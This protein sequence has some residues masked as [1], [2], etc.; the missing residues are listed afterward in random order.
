MNMKGAEKF[1]CRK[2]L[3]GQMPIL[4]KYKNNVEKSFY[5]FHF[6]DII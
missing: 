1:I 4:E 2:G 5:V 6:C 3:Y